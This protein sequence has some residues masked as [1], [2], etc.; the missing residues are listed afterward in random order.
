MSFL[1]K[2]PY[3]LL[4]DTKSDMD[5]GTIACQAQR[6]REHKVSHKKEYNANEDFLVSFTNAYT[7]IHVECSEN[8]GCHLNSQ[9]THSE[10]SST[11]P[12]GTYHSHTGGGPGEE[13]RNLTLSK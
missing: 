4:W 6:L 7:F 5:L 11:E 3:T 8:S 9:W 2:L 10:N 12:P 13:L 1:G